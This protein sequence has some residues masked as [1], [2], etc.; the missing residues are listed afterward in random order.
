MPILQTVSPH[1]G[2]LLHRH[3]MA[4]QAMV[5]EAVDIA[6]KIQ[7]EWAAVPLTARAAVLRDIAK[8]IETH[9]DELAE[10]VRTEMGKPLPDAMS[11]D[12]A[13]AAGVFAT[14]ANWG[15]K[16]FSPQTFGLANGWRAWSM[17]RTHQ[18]Q[19]QPKGVLAVI[20]PWNYPLSI[21]S[22][23]IAASLMA[24]NSVILKPSELTPACGEKLIELV[25]IVLQQHGM[26]P[27]LAQCLIGDGQVGQWLVN[28]D[29]DH[30]IFTGSSAVGE[31][32]QTQL[33]QR[34]LPSTLE[35]GGSCPLIALPE[36]CA[37]DLHGLA[38][39]IV[40]GRCVNSGQTC[41]AVKRVIVA[42]GYR[43]R[44]VVALKQQMSELTFDIV[45]SGQHSPGH[46]GP[47]VSVEQQQRLHQQVMA[48][49]QQGGR[50]VLGGNLP[51]HGP[52]TAGAYYPPTLITHLPSDAPVLQE[53]F[54]GPVLLVQSYNNVN[55]AIELA[56]NTPYGLTASVFG[57]E[58]TARRVASQLQA[59]LVAVNDVA[60][61]HYSFLHLPWQ[62]WQASGTSGGVGS[63]SIQGLQDLAHWHTVAINRSPLTPW[64]FPNNAAND[65]TLGK[66]LL[67]FLSRP[68]W[69]QLAN[70]D[71]LHAVF[72]SS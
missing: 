16:A 51:T 64:L 41:A 30:L 61:A 46:L 5:A 26:E 11:A 3:S 35:L 53:E 24:G 37:R 57:N 32:L 28:S 52:L 62:G 70:M 23:G 19:P 22:W 36:A 14:V 9:A 15:P 33:A 54:F 39:Q 65:T 21:A 10:L 17:G 59:G 38:R 63:H 72:K 45:A 68:W 48:A 4:N 58:D 49:R 8:V 44:L 1:T 56:N 67:K 71:L 7:P 66:G 2:E 20:A 60:A 47:L 25:Q 13:M 29:I 12:V 18:Q 6:C 40:W 50:V 34:N 42:E 43:D 27:L 69:Q 31:K 55:E